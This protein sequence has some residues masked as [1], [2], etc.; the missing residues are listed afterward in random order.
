MKLFGINFGGKKMEAS[1]VPP[2]YS[3]E[4]YDGEKFPGGFGDTKIFWDDYFTLRARSNQLFKENPYARGLLRCLVTNEINTGLTPEVLPNSAILGISEDEL[5]EWAELVEDRFSIWAN[6]PN[7]CDIA[8]QVDFGQLQQNVRLESL[9]GGDVLVVQRLDRRTGLPRIQLIGA[10]S[11]ETPLGMQSSPNLRI[12]HGVELDANG[13][14]IAYH[15]MGATN[16]SIRIPAYGVKSGR[17]LAWLVYGSERRINEVRGEPLLSIVAQSLKELDR[18]KDATQRKAAVNAVLAIFMKKTQDKPG[19]KPLTGGAVR[20]TTISGVAP[21]GTDRKYNIASQIPGFS[22]DELQ[23]GEEPVAFGNQGVDTAFGEFESAIIHAI[24]WSNNVPPEVL[25][26]AFSSN[27]SASQAAINEFKNYLNDFRSRFG[28]NF[29][30]PI[31]EE[32]LLSEVLSG[33]IKADGFLQSWRDTMGFDTYGAWVWSE[34]SGAIKPSTDILKQ[35][36]GYSEM[37]LNGLITRD[38]AAK[39]LT[40]TKFSRNMRTIKRENVIIKEANEILG[41]HGDGVTP[42]SDIEING[43]EDNG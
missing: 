17:R 3:Y 5:G 19:T 43:D 30:K 23:V 37:I 32:W 24:A 12:E 18:Y 21:D 39:E 42:Q 28:T 27:Y 25:T 6:T 11:V 10:A 16:K 38:R 36:R 14:H 13:K 8:K 4:S 29:C 7:L 33:R 40:G 31:Y 15:I 34:W 1:I 41:L 20:K 9:I 26:K 35:A 22:M 2:R